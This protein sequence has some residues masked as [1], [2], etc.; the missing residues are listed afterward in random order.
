M[1]ASNDYSGMWASRL[2]WGLLN[3]ALGGVVLVWPEPSVTV[4]SVLLGAYLVVSAIA[5]L[6]LAFTSDLS[7][8]ARV[9]M[10][11]VGTLS[12]GLGVL[13]FTHLRQ[14]YAVLLLAIWVG[15]ALFLQGMAE[16]VSAICDLAL[17]ERNWH[18][19]IGVVTAIAGLI[20]LAW[21][22]RSITAFAVVA[23]ICLVCVGVSQTMWALRS[24]TD[25]RSQH[26]EQVKSAKLMS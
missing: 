2:T 25:S 24:R 20:M 12:L 11:V 19:F 4:A 14:G 15:A 13:A 9:A 22:L 3:L 16:E 6:L 18:I 5:Q 8:D 7:A 17:P 21:P 1:A 10:L 23:G 26:T